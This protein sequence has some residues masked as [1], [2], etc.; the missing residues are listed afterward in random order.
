MKVGSFRAVEQTCTSD[1]P[2]R[3]VQIGAEPLSVSL[4]T[5]ELNA[6]HG[7]MAAAKKMYRF[8]K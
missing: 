3:F 8:T 5:P 1:P 6:L 4:V 2:L 7:K